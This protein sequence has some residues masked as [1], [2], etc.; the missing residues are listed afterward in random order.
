[1]VTATHQTDE[2]IFYSKLRVIHEYIPYREKWEMD[3]KKE[4]FDKF[5][6]MLLN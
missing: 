3:R 6:D 2:C 1:M 5:T 4:A